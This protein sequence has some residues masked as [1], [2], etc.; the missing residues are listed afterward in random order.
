MMGMNRKTYLIASI[1]LVASVLLFYFFAFEYIVPSA[2]RLAIPYQ[3]KIIPIHQDSSVVH[4]YLGTPVESING[5]GDLKEEWH[6]GSKNQLYI[7]KINYSQQSKTGIGY[8]IEYHFEKWLFRKTF[9]LE[10]RTVN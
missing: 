10:E 1:A 8:R 7:L 3:W 9:L 2:A 6:K 4:A 5:N